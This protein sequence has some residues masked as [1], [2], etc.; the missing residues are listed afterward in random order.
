VQI[1]SGY[2]YVIHTL[3]IVPIIIKVQLKVNDRVANTVFA[4]FDTKFLKEK[5][6]PL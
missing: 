6:V 5:L 2:P 1:Y 4:H 3:N